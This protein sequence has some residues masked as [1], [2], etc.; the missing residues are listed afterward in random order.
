MNINTAGLALIKR[1]E[2]LKLRGYLCPSAVATIGW[3]STQI[4]GR[5]VKP[6]ELITLEQAEA[7]LKL[8]LAIF[9]KGVE[10]AVKVP[11]T[12]NQF[13]ALVSLA[14]NI[15]LGAFRSSS[16][17]KYLNAKQYQLVPD[18]IKR[19]SR[20]GGKILPGLV[21]RRAAEAQLFQAK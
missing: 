13:S 10:A 4:F 12:S 3:G 6:G 14:Y 18:Q 16:L 20:G 17:L 2:G 19:W 8:D 1:S 9:E 21:I 5:K 7:Q 15:G 11:L